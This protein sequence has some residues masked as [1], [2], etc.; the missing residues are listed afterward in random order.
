VTPAARFAAG[1]VAGDR[2]AS[3]IGVEVDRVLDC[4]P[5]RG[6]RVVDRRR[7]AVLGCEPVIN[8]EDRHVGVERNEPACVVVRFEVAHDEAPAVEIHEQPAVLADPGGRI[9]VGSERAG[10]TGDRDLLDARDLWLGAAERS[11]VFGD[12]HSPRSRAECLE[13]R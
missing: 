8:R 11:R 4:E 5:K 6:E 3:R 12:L 7:E 10:R 2:D 1:A 9:E 13:R